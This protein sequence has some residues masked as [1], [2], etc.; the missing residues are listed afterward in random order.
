GGPVRHG[1]DRRPHAAGGRRA[2][3]SAP[4]CPPSAD[5]SDPADR[6]RSDGRRAGA[7]RLGSGGRGAV[8]NPWRFSL[9]AGGGQTYR[10]ARSPARVM[11]AL[12]TT[13]TPSPIPSSA[14]R[15]AASS[16]VATY[17]PPDGSAR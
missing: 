10:P 8:R 1:G 9:A 11:L 13:W 17:R 3:Q 16:Q 2:Y 12:S 5:R 6:R 7:G 4:I 14:P 15:S